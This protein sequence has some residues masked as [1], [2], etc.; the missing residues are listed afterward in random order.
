MLCDSTDMC[1]FYCLLAWAWEEECFHFPH[2][3]TFLR[4]LA[5]F[6][7]LSM[8]LCA[9]AGYGVR[10]HYLTCVNFI[11]TNISRAFVSVNFR[12]VD[13]GRPTNRQTHTHVHHI[14]QDTSVHF[15]KYEL[16]NLLLALFGRALDS[17]IPL[18]PQ[19]AFIEC[20][21]MSCEMWI[22]FNINNNDKS[23]AYTPFIFLPTIFA[24]SP[25]WRR[26]NVSR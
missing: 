22:G 26:W 20:L 6:P 19:M 11:F 10:L 8:V 3:Y 16:P 18:P 1:F 12:P 7:E 23:T 2:D 25:N 24:E 5:Q 14:Q 9:C 15:I 21:A 17:V 13:C 4:W